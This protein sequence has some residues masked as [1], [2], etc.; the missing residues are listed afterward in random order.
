MYS[1]EEEVEQSTEMACSFEGFEEHIY[2]CPSGYP[3]VGYGRNLDIYP[4]AEGELLPM[5]P[6][7]SKDWVRTKIKQD[8]KDVMLLIP[9]VILM[10]P[11]VR[12]VL[13]D[14]AFNL[15]IT[16]LGKFKNMLA[17]IRVSDYKKA[18]DE[19]RDSRYYKQ[20]GR[21]ARAHYRTLKEL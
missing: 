17:A 20:T 16:G 13:T 5:T 2:T 1:I 7:A 18:A 9:P 12:L 21:R 15:G 8:R 14:M 4:L 19:L 3:T 11:E 10:E 6:Q